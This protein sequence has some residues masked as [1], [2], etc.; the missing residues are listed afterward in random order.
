MDN[1]SETL[2]A[3]QHELENLRR[4]LSRREARIEA[5]ETEAKVRSRWDEDLRLAAENLDAKL[6][7]RDREIAE[8]RRSQQ[9]L[10]EALEWRREN[11]E[12]LRETEK[13]LRETEQRL[14]EDIKA[15]QGQLAALEQTRLWRIGQRY[16]RFKDAVRGGL[17][18]EGR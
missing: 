13:S 7:R 14:E 6:L 11:E 3:R 18:R 17:R 8:L 4:E 5:L 10:L 16:W 2:A 15:L 12:S 9:S 1:L